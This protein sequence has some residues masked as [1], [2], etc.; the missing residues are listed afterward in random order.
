MKN[1]HPLEGRKQSS[2][3]IEN[4]TKILRGK[5]RTPEQKKRMSDARLRLKIKMSPEEIANRTE[6]RRKNGWNKNPEETSRRMS[7]NTA[8]AN[9]G[10]KFSKETNAKKGSQKENNPAWKGGVTTENDLIRKSTEYILWRRSCLER[11]NFTCQKTGQRGG[12]L[13]VHHINNF[14]EKKELRLAID[15]G[16]TLSVESHRE[17][18]RRYG[19]KNNTREQLIEFL[20]D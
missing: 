17:F 9:L 8:R 6:V 5:K 20:N 18:H 10:R 19:I 2:E 7:E 13:V 15:N 1:K 3:H 14:A 12:K 11:D 16:I 4:R